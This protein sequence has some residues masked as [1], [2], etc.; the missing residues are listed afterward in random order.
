MRTASMSVAENEAAENGD[1]ERVEDLAARFVGCN[2]ERHECEAR[3]E[4]REQHRRQ[5]F[6]RAPD[7][8]RASELLAFVEGEIDVVADL[9]NAVACRNACERNEADEARDRERQTRAKGCNG[10]DEASGMDIRIVPA[11]TADL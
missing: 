9:Q 10:T 5:P 3:G 2:H 6:E 7:D 4:G 8:E 11:S 1:G